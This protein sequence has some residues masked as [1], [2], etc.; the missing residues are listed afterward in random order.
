MKMVPSG[1]TVQSPTE[2]EESDQDQ[3]E[4]PDAL[5]PIQ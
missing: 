1:M 4:D 5:D 2:R 3:M